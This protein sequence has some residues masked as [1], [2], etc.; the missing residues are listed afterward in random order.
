MVFILLEGKEGFV[1]YALHIHK[2]AGKEQ[3]KNKNYS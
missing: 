3:V 1:H 2:Y